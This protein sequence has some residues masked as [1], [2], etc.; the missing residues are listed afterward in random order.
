MNSADDREP[1]H[2]PVADEAWGETVE[3]SGDEDWITTEPALHV[4]G[5]KKGGSAGG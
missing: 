3:I 2:L 1:L 5:M 4:L